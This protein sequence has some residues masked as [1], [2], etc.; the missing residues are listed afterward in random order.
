M[1]S[2]DEQPQKYE[3]CAVTVEDDVENGSRPL[4]DK[5]AASS[6]F[7][8][9]NDV[10]DKLAKGEQRVLNLNMDASEWGMFPLNPPGDESD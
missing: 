2:T 5:T 4:D 6:G 3:S 9:T 1:H 8:T 7:Q 10:D